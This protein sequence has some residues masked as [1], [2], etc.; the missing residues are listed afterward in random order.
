MDE[1]VDGIGL[2]SSVLITIMFVPQVVHVYRTKDTNAIDYSF[3]F[4]NLLASAMALIYSIYYTVVPMI[5]ANTSAGLFSLSLLSM[6][7]LK[8]KIPDL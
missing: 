4:L 8:E 7:G 1:V 5:V 2:A 3:L 6:K